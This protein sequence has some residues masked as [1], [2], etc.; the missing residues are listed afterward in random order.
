MSKRRFA[1]PNDPG[2]RR[3]QQSGEERHHSPMTSA[4]AYEE[5]TILS[6]QVVIWRC[7]HLY[8]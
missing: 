8:N 6:Q 2:K 1:Q 5:E 4:N 3:M 7:E